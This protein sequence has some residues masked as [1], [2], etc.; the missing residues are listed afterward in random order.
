[1]N[2]KKIELKEETFKYVDCVVKPEIFCPAFLIMPSVEEYSVTVK[3][4]IDYNKFFTF[5]L[6]ETKYGSTEVYDYLVYWD[7]LN[8]FFD[9]IAIFIVTAKD[10]NGGAKE[11]FQNWYNMYNELK[12][13]IEIW[14]A[15]QMKFQK[16]CYNFY[17]A[18]SGK[19]NYDKLTMLAE[20]LDEYTSIRN[21][22]TLDASYNSIKKLF[23]VLTNC[24]MIKNQFSDDAVLLATNMK[25]AIENLIAGG[26]DI[27]KN[28]RI[29]GAAIYKSCMSSLDTENK[30]MFPFS[31]SP[32]IFL[33]DIWDD[34]NVDENVLEANIQS[35][36]QRQAENAQREEN[37]ANELLQKM[38]QIND[39]FL[40]V[41]RARIEEREQSK[42]FQVSSED[43]NDLEN[44]LIG[45]MQ[46]DNYRK[47]YLD[48]QI[49][50]AI[51]AN[52]EVT[53]ILINNKYIQ[54]IDTFIE[55][56][57]L[58]KEKRDL[59]NQVNINQAQTSLNNAISDRME[60][61]TNENPSGASVEQTQV[62]PQVQTQ[63]QTQVPEK[64]F[65][66]TEYIMAA[67]DNSVIANQAGGGAAQFYSDIITLSDRYQNYQPEVAS[68]NSLQNLYGIYKLTPNVIDAVSQFY[69]LDPKNMMNYKMQYRKSPGYKFT[70][71]VAADILNK[72][73]ALDEASISSLKTGASVS[74]STQKPL[75]KTTKTR[76]KK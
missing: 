24:Q 67:L 8:Y 52:K 66:P 54:V 30:I 28:L 49:L 32:G 40:P 20:K 2:E 27:V 68:L 13:M 17:H 71:D 16:I 22:L 4:D 9:F 59:E 3:M 70:D 11:K 65:T 64:N 47:N 18:F 63:T 58:E 57:R 69:G 60:T 51:N 29:I 56:K 45:V 23:S 14:K 33:G 10:L 12:P 42:G 55:K 5:L 34:G 1:M 37:Q 41:I 15:N 25:T 74:A 43:Q 39:S 72:G 73:I 6:E 50:D 48:K 76:K 44:L 38:D 53:D 31:V 26:E 7:T 21:R 75:F 62:Q 46:R 61:E 19:I 35:F 36:Q